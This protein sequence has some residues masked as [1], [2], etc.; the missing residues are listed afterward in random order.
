[1]KPRKTPK[2]KPRHAY[3]THAFGS[4]VLRKPGKRK[5]EPHVESADGQE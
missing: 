1:M 4:R 5:A 3:R 2:P